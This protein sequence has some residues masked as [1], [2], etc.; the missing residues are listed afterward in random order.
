M[1]NKIKTL[2]KLSQIAQKLKDE[3]KKIVLCHGVFDLLHPGHI[4]HFTS[5]KKHGD[6][7]VVTLT[8]D[9]YVK[10]G[11]DRPVFSEE[12]RAEVLASLSMID[13]IAINNGESAV[14]A[15]KA[16]KPDFYAKG[17]DYQ[18][19]KLNSNVV[20]KLSEE[21]K[22]VNSLGGKLVFTDD[23]TFSSSHLINS[24]LDVYTPQTKEFLDRFRLKYSDDAVISYLD[25]L[26]HKKI[27]VIGD[28]IID[29]YHYSS[30]IGKSSK[31][32][33]VV[34]KFLEEESF[35]GGTLATANHISAIADNLTL[36]TLLGKT[37]S[38]ESFTRKHLRRPITVKIFWR[39]GSTII[40]RRYIDRDTKQKLF[41]ISYIDDSE[42]N[43]GLEQSIIRYLKSEI[44]KF[45]LVVVNDYGHGFLTKKIIRLLCEKSKYLAVNAQANSANYGFHVITKY[46][47][48]D[49]VCID[50]MELRLAMHDRWGKVEDLMR[51]VSALTHCENML[52]TRGPYGSMGYSKMSGF[53]MVPAFTRKIVDRVGAG[54]ALFSIAAPCAFQGLDLELVAFLGNIAAALKIQTIGNKNPI[55][56]KE[57]TKFITR[58]L[59]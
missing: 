2:A 8:A 19:R 4:R 37:H 50:D 40:K 58:L 24:Y 41:Q 35:A 31:E 21:E 56:F 59:K 9:R 27:L 3:G 22:T 26:R 20:R 28:A 36:V 13:F 15:I 1:Q 39:N 45:D 25:D 18:K 38:F 17:A 6:I 57:M 44:P 53:I 52:V 29:Q 42:I 16:I 32:P 48:V 33:I 43:G 51:D 11:P 30:P 5:A 54:D 23:I 7:L 55:D 46:P 10:K 49:F 47:K 34:H 12:L 14:D